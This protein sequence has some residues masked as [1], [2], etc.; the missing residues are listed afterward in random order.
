[1]VKFA[2]QAPHIL[3]SRGNHSFVPRF[4]FRLLAAE[5]SI[6][7]TRGYTMDCLCIGIGSECIFSKL[8]TILRGLVSDNNQSIPIHIYPIPLCFTPLN[9]SQHVSEYNKFH[10]RRSC[11][12][13]MPKWLSLL[14]LIYIYVNTVDVHI[15]GLSAYPNHACLNFGS[16]SVSFCDILSE[17]CSTK[18]ICCIVR[19]PKGLCLC[20]ER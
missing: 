12:K 18:S 2:L 15:R 5:N 7:Y 14:L 9:S 10:D 4:T 16:N 11:P 6:A 3:E 1:M 13:G 19:S 17:N 8:T 20:S